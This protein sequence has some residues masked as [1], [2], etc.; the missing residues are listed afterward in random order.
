M[1]ESAIT[2]VP[3]DREQGWIE[4]DLFATALVGKFI[5]TFGAEALDWDAATIE[6]EVEEAAGRKLPPGNYARLMAGITILT[7]DLFF[8]DLPGFLQLATVL[9]GDVPVEGMTHEPDALECAWAII[10]GLLISPPDDRDEEPFCDDIR[11]YI[12][13]QL[14]EEGILAAPDVLEIAIRPTSMSQVA[15]RLPD[16]PGLRE[17]VIAAAS[18]RSDDI[19][20]TLATS[21]ATLNQ[22]LHH[23]KAD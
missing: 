23:L 20:Q 13:F 5:K 12:G 1:S 16:D 3:R 9:S 6:L 14:D 11:K 18:A 15:S 19:T 21:L 17:H 4:P 7:R 22:Q 8:K 2:Q 10:E